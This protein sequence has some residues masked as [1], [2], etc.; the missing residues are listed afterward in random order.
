MKETTYALKN[1]FWINVK[2]NLFDFGLNNDIILND[3]NL[4]YYISDTLFFIK[5]ENN[6]HIYSAIPE[7]EHGKN[8]AIEL[9]SFSNTSKNVFADVTIDN[10]CYTIDYNCQVTSTS[11]TKSQKK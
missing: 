3:C 2:G 5:K 4:F 6:I 9:A 7:E 1:G 8:K 10:I 11:R